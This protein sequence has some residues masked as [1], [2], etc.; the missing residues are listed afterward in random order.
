M[1]KLS[2]FQRKVK[3]R[4]ERCKRKELNSCQVPLPVVS[5][6]SERWLNFACVCVCVCVCVRACVC[7][8]FCAKHKGREQ[9]T[10]KSCSWS[11]PTPFMNSL[12]DYVCTVAQ[13]LELCHDDIKCCV[14]SL[15]E[16]VE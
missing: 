4:V 16:P 9:S 8:G 14:L 11:P 1:V 15:S 6:V 7:C 13:C 3:Q 12:V 5:E 10:T 2:E